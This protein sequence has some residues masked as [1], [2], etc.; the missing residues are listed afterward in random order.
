MLYFNV[1]KYCFS[2]FKNKFCFRRK[3]QKIYFIESK[4]DKIACNKI[5][6]NLGNKFIPLILYVN[7]SFK[8]Q[9]LEV[10]KLL[11]YTGHRVASNLK[12]S[13]SRLILGSRLKTEELFYSRVHILSTLRHYLGWFLYCKTNQ[14]NENIVLD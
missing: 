10:S 7:T 13:H 6:G 11:Y 5:H 12:K 9:I 3:F 14:L 1:F 8:F 4:K 2:F